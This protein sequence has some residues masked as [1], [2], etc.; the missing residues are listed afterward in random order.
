MQVSIGG[1]QSDVSSWL[2]A[3][4]TKTYNAS[5]LFIK[6]CVYEPAFKYVADYNQLVVARRI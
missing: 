3:F 2:L 4:I 6:T 5:V 1:S